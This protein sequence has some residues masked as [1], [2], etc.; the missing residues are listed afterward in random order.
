MKFEMPI[1]VL[2]GQKGTMVESTDPKTGELTKL[3]EPIY[4]ASLQALKDSEIEQNKFG[5]KP[6]KLPCTHEVFD[7]IRSLW[8]DQK[9][10]FTVICEMRTVRDGRGAEKMTPFAI[11]L[12]EKA[13]K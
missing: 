6:L 2:S 5:Y 12:I 4:W 11:E 9:T 8:S 7:Q 3:K 1:N 13:T 10:K